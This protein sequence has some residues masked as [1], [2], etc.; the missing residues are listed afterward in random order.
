MEAECLP[1]SQL[2]G[3]SRL[4]LDY[5]SGKVG[6]PFYPAPAGQLPSQ[7][8]K[9]FP[10]DRRKKVA[11]V[12]AVQNRALGASAKTLANI[13]KLRAC[14]SA[15]VTGQQV[16]LFG[17]PAFA[18]YKALTAINVA[19]ELSKRG[20]ESVPIFWL[21]TQDH[22][23]AEVQSTLLRSPA[24]ELQEFSIAANA[25]ADTPVAKIKLGA[26]I[27]ALAGEAA[28]FLGG[29]F[30]ELLIECYQPEE[31]LGSAM[32][33]L[34]AKI[35]AE[36]GLIVVDPLH[37]ELQKLAAP[38]Y[39]EVVKMRDEL[40]RRLL[41]RGKELEAAG[42]HQQVKV[43]PSS[44]L[45]FVEIDG[46]RTPVRR[47]NGNFAAAERRYTEAQ[48]IEHIN[49]LPEAI[50]GNAL[51]RPIIQD[52]LL[53]TIAY[54]GGPAEVAYFA[55]A[56]VVY[57]KLL[58]RVTPIIPRLSATLLDARDQRLLAEYGLSLRDVI[59][60]DAKL[61]EVL[62]AQKLGGNVEQAFH[63]AERSVQKEIGGLE[64]QLQQLDATL[65]DATKRSRS[66]IEYQLSR[67]RS[68]AAHAL[69]RRSGEL[70]GHAESLRKS[71]FPRGELQERHI[72][73]VSYLARFG[74]DLVRRLEAAARSDCKGHHVIKL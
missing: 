49:K 1:F 51:L 67:L 23:F 6:S 25:P 30:S 46:A 26:Q 37:P 34:F 73:G 45:L 54:I 14:A 33:R 31:T 66:K 29:E 9:D 61:G 18:I 68:K 16:T 60:H 20:V 28:E 69:L 38:V 59:E 71:L 32:G 70:S 13:E 63:N 27:E 44:T 4:F 39:Q 52:Y 7:G 35:F 65:A 10:E 24:G 17:G 8:R 57:E 5:V 11:E 62:A 64:K 72:A 55:Q 53:P 12:L 36:H 41:E 74:E 21:A 50:S 56:G 19:Q 48:L 3:T 42:Y 22:D 43:T 47:S 40:D 15:V 58:G 2:P